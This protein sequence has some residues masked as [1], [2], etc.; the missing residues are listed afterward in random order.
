MFLSL[1]PIIIILL[2]AIMPLT[3]MS[4]ATDDALELTFAQNLETPEVPKKAKEYV[5]IHMDQLRRN[6]AK[7]GLDVKT[8]RNGEVLQ[9]T[10]PCEV[11]F[12]IGSIELKQSAVNELHKLGAV[13]R[14]PLKYKVVIGVHTDDTGDEQ[15]ADSISAARANALDDGLWQIAGEID[16]N[17]IPY[18]I[19]KDEPLAPNTSRVNRARNRRAEFFIIPETGLLEMAGVK[20]KK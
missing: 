13:V 1:K 18:G 12:G 9:V 8:V 4:Q 20:P 15:Y 7:N 5:R 10:I 2:A 16:T 11:L 17:V 3:A 6:L 14:D 19:G